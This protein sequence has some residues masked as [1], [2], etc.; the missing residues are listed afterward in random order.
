MDKYRR[1]YVPPQ[2]PADNEVRISNRTLISGVINYIQNVFVEKQFKTIDII[3]TSTAIEKAIKVALYLRKRSKGLSLITKIFNIETSDIYEPIEEGLDQVELKRK[4]PAIKITASF[5][6]QNSK[7]PGYLEPLSES[8]FQAI[9]ANIEEKLPERGR[10]RR[11]RM[12][13]RNRSPRG[14]RN[15]NNFNEENRSDQKDNDRNEKNQGYENH[16]GRYR[17]GRMRGRRDNGEK[18]IFGKPRI[19]EEKEEEK[20]NVSEKINKEHEDSGWS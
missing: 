6:P 12:R 5:Q 10:F 13:G 16:R 11:G 14:N 3:G 1:I 15:Y 20:K 18:R 19:K 17:R 8:E 9:N 7:D 4:I 2:K